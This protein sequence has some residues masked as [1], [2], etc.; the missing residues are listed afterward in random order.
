LETKTL[1]GG[2]DVSVPKQKNWW[3]PWLLLMLLISVRRRV[4]VAMV[5]AVAAHGYCD[6]L[7]PVVDR[8]Y[9]SCYRKYA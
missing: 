1:L 8:R 2:H 9:F 7:P 4:V 3:G 5:L 6:W